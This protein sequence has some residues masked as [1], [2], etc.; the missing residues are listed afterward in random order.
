VSYL[1]RFAR[2]WWTFVVGDNL[3]LALGAG[4][5]IAVTALLVDQG[6]NAWW[7]LP[8]GIL[9]L[10]AVSVIR[11]ADPGNPLDSLRRRRDSK[12]LWQLGRR[13]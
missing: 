2:F 6:V 1:R 7:L 8:V 10:L 5:M 11:V 4:A 3:P 9:G 13:G 12:R